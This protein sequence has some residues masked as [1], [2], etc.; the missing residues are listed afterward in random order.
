MLQVRVEHPFIRLWLASKGVL[1]YFD[2]SIRTSEEPLLL[3]KSG[4][5]STVS[6]LT[7]SPLGV[8]Q[9]EEEVLRKVFNVITSGGSHITFESFKATL[10]GVG[11]GA[12]AT[13]SIDTR[14]SGASDRRSS[15]RTR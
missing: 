2:L 15:D 8:A 11:A 4:H 9:F 10:M 13:T 12:G 5:G 7:I 14:Q 3:T 6:Q 1:A